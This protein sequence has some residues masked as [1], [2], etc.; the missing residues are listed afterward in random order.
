MNRMSISGGRLL[1]VDDDALL[2]GMAAKTL[3]HAGFEVIEAA[4]GEVAL[5]Q[6]ETAPFDLLLLDVVM[7][8]LDGYEVCARIRALAHGA[9]VPIL[10]LT[11]LNDSASIELAYQAGA[12]DFIAKPINW[13]LLTHRV[14]YSLRAGAAVEQAMRSRERLERAQH[15]ANMGSWEIALPDGAFACSPELGRVFGASDEAVTCA[16]SADFLARVCEADRETVRLARQAAM[17]MGQAYQLSFAI[18]RFDGTQRTVFEQASAVLDNTGQPIAIEGITQ[19]ITDRVE[20]ERRIRHLAHYD[21][22]TG[23]PNRQFF[24]ELAGPT[25]ERSRRLGTACALL[26]VDIDRFKSVNDAYGHAEGDAVLLALTERLQASIRACDLAMVGGAASDSVVARVGANAFTLLLVDVGNDA[27]A[28]LVAERL[29]Q[30]VAAPIALRGRKLV[31]TTSIGI[32]MYPRDAGDAKGLA[33]CAEQA[34]YAAKAAGRARHSFFDEAMNLLA[35]DR[36]ARESDLRHA[37]A[38]GQLRLQYQPKVDAS[39]GTIL[40][41]EALVRW[42]HPERGLVPPGLFIPLAEESGLIL[43]LTD[44]VLETACADQ[45]ARLDAGLRA[46]PISVNL[47]APSFV[48]DGLLTQLDELLARHRLD[49]SCLTFEVTESQLMTN[50]D[51]AVERLHELRERGFGLSLDDFGTGYSSLSYLKRF[52]VHELK[53]DRSFVVDVCSGGRDGALAASIIALGREFG[54][55]VVAEGV[56]TAEQAA[57]LLGHGCPHQQ[58]YLF[59][60]PMPV[61]AFDALLVGGVVAERARPLVGVD[62]YAA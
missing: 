49:A 33:R 55:R 5:Q 62:L 13:T 34:A 22:L 19:D 3:R 37:I 47:A 25:L 23:L 10:M 6:F 30:A 17:R 20:A 40:G 8:E 61:A 51:R 36:L 18:T 9:R 58:G 28:A 60:R 12:T 32:A 4:D 29:L 24:D 1:L 14:R 59:A 56:E 38:E 53:I 41:A 15:I 45:R 11:G 48:Y 39:S 44:W 21:G 54:L 46:V 7:P 27:Q 52:P 57:F 31:L 16:T 2:R 43:P 50:I 42:L 35:S 26:H